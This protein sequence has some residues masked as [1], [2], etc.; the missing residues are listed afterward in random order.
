VV[1]SQSGGGFVSVEIG[2]SAPLIVP[3]DFPGWILYE[4]ERLLVVN[5]PALIVCHPSKNGPWSSLVGA[6]RE[7]LGLPTM[8]LVFRLDRETSGV[9]VLAKDSATAS[10][11]QKATQQRLIGKVYLSILTG[12]LP[13]PTTVDQWLGPDPDSCVTIRSKVVPAGTPGAQTAVTHFEPLAVAGGFTLA[14]VRLETGRKHQIRA[15]AL[16]LGHPIVGDKLYGPDE[17]LYLEFAQQ[18][19][20]ERHAAL[21]PLPRQALHCSEIDLR[22]A[23][24]QHLFHADLAAELAQFCRERMGIDPAKNGAG[25]L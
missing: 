2:A 3:E 24:E 11:L 25:H 16:W 18:G 17:R 9:V 13:Q 22:P 19:W 23:R 10:K 1:R 20:T 21:L 6:A 7:Y 14:R 8:H 5:K 15:H 4:D 12:E